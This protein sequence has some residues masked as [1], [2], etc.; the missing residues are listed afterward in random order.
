MVGS[1]RNARETTGLTA[2]AAFMERL[3]LLTGTGDAGV[4]APNAKNPSDAPAEQRTNPKKIRGL[5]N[6]DLDVDLLFMVMSYFTNRNSV[7][8][9]PPPGHASLLSYTARRSP[10]SVS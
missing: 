1:S 9:W 3:R 2:P 4:P 8:R 6:P 7:E 5:K 10:A